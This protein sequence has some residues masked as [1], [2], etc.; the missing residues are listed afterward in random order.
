MFPQVDT[1]NLAAVEA[2]VQGCFLRMFPDGDGSFIKNGFEW[3]ATCF[4]GRHPNYQPIDAR[5]HDLEHTLQGTLCLA[6]IL[7]GRNRAAAKPVLERSTCELALLAILFHDTGYLKTAEDR[8]GTG[9]KYTLTHVA[10]SA[11]FADHFLASKG[12]SEADRES[13]RDMICCT[14]VNVDLGQLP[15]PNEQVRI[16]G[17]AL[18]T[19][20]LLGQMAAPDYIDKLHILYEEFAEAAK[21]SGVPGMFASADDLRRKT[22]AFWQKYVL[23]KLN[24]DFL[25]VYRFL[26]S[27]LPDGPNWYIDRIEENLRRLKRELEAAS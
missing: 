11:E 22:G 20:D 14:G 2:E 15:F 23:P 9:A 24:D 21:F 27:P 16:A 6:R 25:G 26:N 8:E 17:F 13:V 19:G 5:Y 18:G 12:V 10:R 3:M 7:E 1:K 4:E